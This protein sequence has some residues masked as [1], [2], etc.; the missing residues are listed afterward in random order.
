MGLPPSAGAGAS[1]SIPEVGVLGGT[2]GSAGT[3]SLGV[4]SALCVGEGDGDGCGLG[5][6]AGGGEAVGVGVGSAVGASVGASVGVSTGESVGACSAGGAGTRPGGRVGFGDAVGEGESDAMGFGA[7]AGAKATGRSSSIEPV[8]VTARRRAAAVTERATT[9][10]VQY[11][12]VGSIVGA[13]VSPEDPPFGTP[14][15]GGDGLT[16]VLSGCCVPP[17]GITAVVGTPSETSS[18]G[19]FASS[20]PSGFSCLGGMSPTAIHPH[21]HGK[22]AWKTS[23]FADRQPRLYYR[24]RAVVHS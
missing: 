5:T 9:V 18:A 16:G 1:L 6:S 14:A 13:A 20:S 15:A 7:G 17:A 21:S 22:S 11:V 23:L 2:C 19:A 8:T 10:R 4:G 3:V 12:G 24:L